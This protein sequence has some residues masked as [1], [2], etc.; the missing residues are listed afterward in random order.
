[1]HGI[2]AMLSIES[3]ARSVFSPIR[4]AAS[5]ASTPACPAPM[6]ITSYVPA[7][8]CMCRPPM[9]KACRIGRLEQFLLHDT[10]GRVMFQAAFFYWS[11]AMLDARMA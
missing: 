3:V 11:G 2:S 8:N 1:L 4:A 10:T 6:T 5:A 9:K 7:T